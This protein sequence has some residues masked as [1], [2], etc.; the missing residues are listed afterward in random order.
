MKLAGY[1]SMLNNPKREQ[2]FI[3]TEE[4]KRNQVTEEN[5]Y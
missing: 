1:Y 2:G 5:F 3:V 4:K